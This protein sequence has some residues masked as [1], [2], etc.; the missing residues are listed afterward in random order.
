[1][2]N[3]TQAGQRLRTI[4]E[5]LTDQILEDSQSL[6]DVEHHPTH[7][8]DADD[9]NRK[10]YKKRIQRLRE[11]RNELEELWTGASA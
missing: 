4:L 7:D 3:I 9:D 11:I 6:Y 2:S 5:N 8:P 1:M 10:A